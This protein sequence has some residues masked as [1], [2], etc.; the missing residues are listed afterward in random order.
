MFQ[1]KLMMLM[2]NVMWIERSCRLSHVS[3]LN[4]SLLQSMDLLT[5]CMRENSSVKIEHYRE[6]NC[7]TSTLG[8]GGSVVFYTFSEELAGK[9]I[10]DNGERV[11]A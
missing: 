6:E 10:V 1:D 3:S 11:E 7:S 2:M 9:L 4:G 8:K 5:W